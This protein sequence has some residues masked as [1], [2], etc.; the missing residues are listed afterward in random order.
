LGELDGIAYLQGGLGIGIE[1]PFD[2]LVGHA[3]VFPLSAGICADLTQT[4]VGMLAFQHQDFCNLGVGDFER[5]Q[6]VSRGVSVR[7]DSF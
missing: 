6:G 7:G 1:I 4:Q 3:K 5:H 2:G